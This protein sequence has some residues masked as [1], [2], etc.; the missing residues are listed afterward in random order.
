[1]VRIHIHIFLQ[2]KSTNHACFE[3]LYSTCR[4]LVII[5][6]PTISCYLQNQIYDTCVHVLLPAVDSF[7]VSVVDCGFVKLRAFSP[8]TSLGR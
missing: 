3:K 1:M 8:K 6:V 5:I 4:L 7:I 2:T